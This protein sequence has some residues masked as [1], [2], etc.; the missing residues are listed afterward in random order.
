MNSG[1]WNL[2]VAT[3]FPKGP[4][5]PSLHS[6]HHVCLQSVNG[7]CLGQGKNRSVWAGW[8]NVGNFPEFALGLCIK[9]GFA[10][11]WGLLVRNPCF[12]EESF[13]LCILMQNNS[14]SGKVCMLYHLLHCCL[15]F[16]FFFACIQSF[17]PVIWLTA[18]LSW[19]SWYL[20]LFWVWCV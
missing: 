4:P 6:L 7:L 12:Y 20:S 14:I 9:R 10:G 13:S 19:F 17:F 3:S 2:L 18:V 11:T 1:E 5:A 8:S 15:W 16:D